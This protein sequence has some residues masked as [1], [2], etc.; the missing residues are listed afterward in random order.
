M[1]WI[2]WLGNIALFLISLIIQRERK[3]INKQTVLTILVGL[4]L[5]FEGSH[6][7][8]GPKAVHLYWDK[9]LKQTNKTSHLENNNI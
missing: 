7:Y 6:P 2:S 8:V 1:Q 9:T 3:G 4:H 5:A